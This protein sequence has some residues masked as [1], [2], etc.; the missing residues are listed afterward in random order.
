VCGSERSLVE[1]Q[2]RTADPQP[3]LADGLSTRDAT[4]APAEAK[5]DSDRQGQRVAKAIG[6]W[7]DAVLAQS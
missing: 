2:Q 3:E 1:G 7:T 4:R 5:P 6:T